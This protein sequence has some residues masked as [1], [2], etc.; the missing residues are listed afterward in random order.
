MRWSCQLTHYSSFSSSELSVCYLDHSDCVHTSKEKHKWVWGLPSEVFRLMRTVKSHQKTGYP[1]KRNCQPQGN[2][3]KPGFH[4]YVVME[5]PSLQIHLLLRT[6][7]YFEYSSQD[8]T[9]E[10]WAKLLLQLLWQQSRGHEYILNTHRDM[11][12]PNNTQGC[13][14]RTAKKSSY[15]TAFSNHAE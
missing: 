1:L 14:Q 5:K 3:L 7:S 4:P 10:I 2:V 8:C 9:A 13:Y 12:C 6:M 11:Y 15:F